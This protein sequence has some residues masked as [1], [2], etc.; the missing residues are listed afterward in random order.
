MKQA[1]VWIYDEIGFWGVTASDFAQDIA[2]LDVEEITLRL[3]SPGGD[4]YDGIAIM[5]ALMDHKAK[6]TVKIDAL[7]ASIASVI[8]MAGDE[9]VMG[10]HS[11][12]M[13][14]DASTLGYGDAAALREVADMLDRVSNNIA[15]VYAER[16]G[17]DS[18][19]WREKMLA[20]T[21]FTAAEAVEAGLADRVAE[22]PA[23]RSEEDPEARMSQRVA[24]QFSRSGFRY[25]GRSV[26]PAPAAVLRNDAET[27]RENDAPQVGDAEPDSYSDL[28]TEAETQVSDSVDENDPATDDFADFGSLFAEAMRESMDSC[29]TAL[30]MDVF[31]EAVRGVTDAD[32][33]VRRDPDP[34]PEPRLFPQDQREEPEPSVIVDPDVAGMSPD[35]FREAVLL[36]ANNAPA[37]VTKEEP[38]KHDQAPDFVI[39]SDDFYN[40]V[41]G[42]LYE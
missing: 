33:P 40:A 4:V 8:A 27:D 24:A 38:E 32:I 6:V 25:A 2:A 13:I 23:R 14:H 19:D 30:D 5:N 16:A 11:E 18:A 1:E 22:K 37:V 34:A 12:F 26:A 42:A 29:E 35:I 41:R 31:H 17:G 21:W 9:V 20:E 3:N 10:P 7:A 28:E 39:D 15:E 36:A